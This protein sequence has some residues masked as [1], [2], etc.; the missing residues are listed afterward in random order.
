VIDT[1]RPLARQLVLLKEHLRR[2]CAEQLPFARF[3][4]AIVFDGETTR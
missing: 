3:V 2:V 1:S 4:N